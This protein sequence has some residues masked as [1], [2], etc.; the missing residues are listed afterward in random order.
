MAFTSCLED[1]ILCAH[2]VGICPLDRLP[3]TLHCTVNLSTVFIDLAIY[4][5]YINMFLFII[6]VNRISIF[7]S[8]R[9][10][11]LV[12]CVFRVAKHFHV[13]FT[14]FA[15]PFCILYIKKDN[16]YRSL[17]IIWQTN[18]ARNKSNCQQ[19]SFA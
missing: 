12:Q 7:N 14:F 9:M 10:D 5:K 1:C 8:C 4:S 6:M 13:S 17:N 15:F 19:M 3:L 2:H 11:L 16:G 18:L